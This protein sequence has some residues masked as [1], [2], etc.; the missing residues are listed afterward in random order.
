[1]GCLA[2]KVALGPTIAV[3]LIG[4]LSARASPA[5][6]G[7]REEMKLLLLDN[8][9]QPRRE[10]RY[11]FQPG[12]VERM[13]LELR[14]SSGPPGKQEAAPLCRVVLKLEAKG[15]SPE[16]DLRYEF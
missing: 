15:V 10:L 3:A 5:G 12:K 11:R 2:A 6:E 9:F 8:G 7:P 1:M 4:V 13:V 16:G 14:T